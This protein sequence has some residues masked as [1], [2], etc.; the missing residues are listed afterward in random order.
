[1]GEEKGKEMG[2]L[3]RREGGPELV[4][5]QYQVDTLR[6]ETE[7]EK[8]ADSQAGKGSGWMVWLS[9][10]NLERLSLVEFGFW[11]A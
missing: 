4:L 7:R 9:G 5:C 10:G 11:S 6:S 8:T 3:R 1:M 2:I